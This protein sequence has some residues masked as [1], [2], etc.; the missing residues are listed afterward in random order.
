MSYFA[1]FTSESLISYL[2]VVR[3]KRVRRNR[4]LESTHIGM[5]DADA[6]NYVNDVS[7]VYTLDYF[8]LI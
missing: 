3:E 8:H 1:Q 5:I 4:V 6:Q 7:I 2:I